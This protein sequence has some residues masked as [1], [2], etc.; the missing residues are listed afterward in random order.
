MSSS[1]EG[2]P[3]DSGNGGGFSGSV[4]LAL[5]MMYFYSLRV[6]IK[7]FM[8]VLYIRGTCPIALMFIEI[9]FPLEFSWSCSR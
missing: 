5:K 2:D 6:K 8:I 1:N 9:C 7:T 3:W 4:Y